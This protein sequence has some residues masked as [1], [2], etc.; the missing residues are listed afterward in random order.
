MQYVTKVKGS[1]N[2]QSVIS[3]VLG[4]VLLIFIGY[5][6]YNAVTSSKVDVDDV[7]EGYVY[8]KYDDYEIKDALTSEELKQICNTFRGKVLQNER[9]ECS[10]AFLGAY[11]IILDDSEEFW[12]S[13]QCGDMIY[14]RDEDKYF[15]LSSEEWNQ[16]EKILNSHGYASVKKLHQN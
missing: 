15:I 5:F 13:G 6:I 4:L 12:L 1:Y 8:F 3:E 10:G 9:C 7:E 2:T 16:L 14:Y 11:K